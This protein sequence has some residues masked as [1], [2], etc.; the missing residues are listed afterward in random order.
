MTEFLVECVA[1]YLYGCAA[2]LDATLVF[3]MRCVLLF[4]ALVIVSHLWT[5]I[6]AVCRYL[7]RGFQCFYHWTF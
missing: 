2:R 5:A 1:S 3:A 6:A 4:L 7:K